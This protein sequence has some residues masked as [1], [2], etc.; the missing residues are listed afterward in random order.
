MLRWYSAL[1]LPAY[2]MLHACDI[3][4]ELQTRVRAES[5]TLAAASSQQ[6]VQT[7]NSTC[8]ASAMQRRQCWQ[9]LQE[10][11]TKQGDH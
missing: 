2:D 4:P 6:E 9:L 5:K 3:L 7:P 8:A 10:A 11:L 1:M